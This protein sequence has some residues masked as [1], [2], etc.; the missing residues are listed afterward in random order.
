[1]L[2]CIVFGFSDRELGK[3]V[4]FGVV[5]GGAVH[6]SAQEWTYI[7]AV[8]LEI[9]PHGANNFAGDYGTRLIGKDVDD[10]HAVATEETVDKTLPETLIGA[11]SREH[12]H[13][14]EELADE[15]ASRSQK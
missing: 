15:H 9:F 6:F 8:L 3:A 11:G 1:M 7:G 5:V 14:L 4:A 2:Y 13:I 12:L 10:K